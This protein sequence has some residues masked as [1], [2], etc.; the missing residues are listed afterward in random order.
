MNNMIDLT[1]GWE[2]ADN[3]PAADVIDLRR[4]RILTMRAICA[5]SFGQQGTSLIGEI[6]SEYHLARR[7]HVANKEVPMRPTHPQAAMDD[8][9]SYQGVKLVRK[10]SIFS[11]Q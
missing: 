9:R 11:G 2:C 5:S 1:R 6:S 7:D 4:P 8:K 3:F 10:P